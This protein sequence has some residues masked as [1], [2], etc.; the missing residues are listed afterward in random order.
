MILARTEEED[1]WWRE[2]VAKTGASA[3]PLAVDDACEYFTYTNP[4]LCA[5][6]AASKCGTWSGAFRLEYRI[7]G[8]RL[9]RMIAYSG[10]PPAEVMISRETFDCLSTDRHARMDAA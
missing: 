4:F 9:I 8:C 6:K 5:F 2:E 10:E 7:S 1:A 3:T